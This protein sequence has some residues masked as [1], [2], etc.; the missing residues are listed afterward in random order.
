MKKNKLTQYDAT[1]G[2][3]L[4]QCRKCRKY[5][6]TEDLF[7]D[8][9]ATVCLLCER[10][11][12][13][14]AG[15]WERARLREPDRRCVGAMRKPKKQV[16]VTVPKIARTPTERRKQLEADGKMPDEVAAIIAKEFPPKKVYEPSRDEVSIK[17][18]MESGEINSIEA[19]RLMKELRHA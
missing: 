10:K 7:S 9:S 16:R 17:R 8:P 11:E 14:A 15:R 4:T 6:D 5:R 18:R 3:I 19:M 13:I 12:A 1:A 2:G